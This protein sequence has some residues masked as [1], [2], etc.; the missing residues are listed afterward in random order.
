MDLQSIPYL[1][2]FYRT[3]AGIRWTPQDILIA[4]FSTLIFAF[5]LR[6]LYII[7][8][9]E[10]T[11]FKKADFIILTFACIS[12]L[13][14]VTIVTTYFPSKK[15]VYKEPQNRPAAVKRMEFIFSSDTLDKYFLNMQAHDSLLLLGLKDIDRNTAYDYINYYNDKLRIT[16]EIEYAD[17]AYWALGII[18]YYTSSDES[19]KYFSRIKNTEL[20]KYNYYMG[21]VQLQRHNLIT[22]EKHFTDEYKNQQKPDPSFLNLYFNLLLQNKN[23]KQAR[24]VYG[25]QKNVLSLNLLNVYFVND[26]KYIEYFKVQSKIFIKNTKFINIVIGLFITFTWFFFLYFSDLFQ[27]EKFRYLLFIVIVESLLVF[28]CPFIYKYLEFNYDWSLS[29]ASTIWQKLIYSVG[30]ISLV[31]ETIKAIPFFIL[32]IF[33]KEPDDSYDYLFYICISALTFSFIENCTYFNSA[34]SFGVYNGRALFSTIAHLYSSTMVGYGF[35]YAKYNKAVKHKFIYIGLFYLGGVLFHGLYDFFLFTNLTLLFYLGYFMSIV[36]W[37]ILLNNSLN[38]SKYFSYKYENRHYYIQLV[39][40]VNLIIVM[41]VE[42]ILNALNNGAIAANTRLLTQIAIYGLVIAFFISRL[43]KYDLVK[44]YWRKIT[45]NGY[46]SESYYFNKFNI[47]SYLGNFFFFNKINPRNYVGMHIKLVDP[48]S[49]Y[50]TTSIYRHINE[51]LNAQII[52]RMVIRKFMVKG[53]DSKYLDDPQWFMIRNCTKPLWDFDQEFLLFK[54]I[55]PFDEISKF[56]PRQIVLFS[57]KSQDILTKEDKQ[58]S[59]FSF[60]GVAGIVLV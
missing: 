36:V 44:G 45:F 51:N 35:M 37:V 43:A 48:K 46:D 47:L 4:I 14:S 12:L 56:K 59:D 7:I 39:I 22:A 20:Y 15:P 41:L 38:N 1:L 34:Q 3:S 21:L 19:L 13:T 27:K 11:D 49:Q 26:L 17:V 24:T 55:S 54:F 8:R 23:L 2:C 5:A 52:D 33:F 58:M 10:K 50:L 16:T 28:A 42:Y 60:V 40:G 9:G 29:N 53:D 31:E 32:L 6:V 57:P 25:A 30:C 18:T